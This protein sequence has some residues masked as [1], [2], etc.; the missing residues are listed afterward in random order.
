MQPKSNDFCPKS[1]FLGHF[2]HFLPVFACFWRITFDLGLEFGGEGYRRV[3][4][5]HIAKFEPVNGSY[6]GV[7]GHCAAQKVTVSRQNRPK[8]GGGGE[9]KTMQ[10]TL[11]DL[12][13]TL[14]VGSGYP[15]YYR[16]SIFFAKIYF[17]RF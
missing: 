16:I 14:C 4:W 12:L 3:L 1:P 13:E 9:T 8:S 11:F 2:C 5:I 15:W 7:R 6:I 17:W 10:M